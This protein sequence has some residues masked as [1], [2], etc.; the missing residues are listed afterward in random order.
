MGAPRSGREAT[1]PGSPEVWEPRGLEAKRSG[2][3]KEWEP[4][5]LEATGPGSPKVWKT[6]GLEAT[7]YGSPKAWEPSSL[8][9]LRFE[10]CRLLQKGALRS[11]AVARVNIGLSHRKLKRGFAPGPTRSLLHIAAHPQT[12]PKSGS[13]TAWE[14]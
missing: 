9:A 12:H 13:N 6:Q 7:G 2:S 14:P 10:S 11:V 5:G 8:E 1:T 3:P 4:Q